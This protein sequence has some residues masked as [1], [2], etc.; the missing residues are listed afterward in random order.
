MAAGAAL[1]LPEG[2]ARLRVAFSAGHT[3]EQVDRLAAALR[4]WL[5]R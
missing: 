4:P 3:D 1:S 2:T 5:A